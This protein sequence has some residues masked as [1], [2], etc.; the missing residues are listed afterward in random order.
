MQHAYCCCWHHSHVGLAREACRLQPEGLACVL[1]C[2][3][4][5]FGVV[6]EMP[7]HEQDT[8]VCDN[9]QRL[10]GSTQ[11]SWVVAAAGTSPCAMH[12]GLDLRAPFTRTAED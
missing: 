2:L 5:V 8:T 11:S 4:Q 6:A 12:I 1:R 7:K 9:P 3:L 10:A